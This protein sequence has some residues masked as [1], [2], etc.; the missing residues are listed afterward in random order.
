MPDEHKVSLMYMASTV[1]AVEMIRPEAEIPIEPGST[2]GILVSM[3]KEG[4]K[5]AM[6]RDEARKLGKWLLETADAIDEDARRYA[7]GEKRP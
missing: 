4:I 3:R 7:K 6:H 2:W 1:E 5:F